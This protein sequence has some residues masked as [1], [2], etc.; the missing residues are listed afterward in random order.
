[1]KRILTLLLAAMLLFSLA[2]CNKTAGPATTAPAT[3]VPP[4][5][6]TALTEPQP[7]APVE[8]TIQQTTLVEQDGLKIVATDLTKTD[9][10]YSLKMD[11]ENNSGEDLFLSNAATYVNNCTVFTALLCEVSDGK[12]AVATLDIYE[13][14][15]EAYG[16]ET[17]GQIGIAFSAVSEDFAEFLSTDLITLD[18]S[19]ADSSRFTPDERWQVLYDQNDIRVLLVELVEEPEGLFS[20]PG[21]RLYIENNRTDAVG[22]YIDTISVNDYMDE[23]F[24]DATL[25]P[26]TQS[27]SLAEL[28]K[29]EENGIEKI[30]TIELTLCFYTP[31][32]LYEELLPAQTVTVQF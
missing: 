25:F 29:L 22:V 31:G 16:F 18:T 7:T 4:T 10:G 11:V 14:D 19:A 30:E 1:M 12:K 28:F 2:A 27:L 15:L 8:A 5:A 17:I 26:G 21:L 32:T 13:E 9:D 3:T 6:T 20:M 24:L 23:A